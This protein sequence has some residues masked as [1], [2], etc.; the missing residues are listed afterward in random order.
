MEGV[1]V[2][3]VALMTFLATLV[4]VPGG[5]EG[6]VWSPGRLARRAGHRAARLMRRLG[7]SAMVS[8]LVGTD[9]G[10]RLALEASSSRAAIALGVGPEGSLAALLC[11]G[12]LVCALF[13]LLLASPLACPVAGLALVGMC[14]SRDAARGRRLRREV[15]GAMPGI[16]RTLAVAMGSG[17]TLAQAVEY[18]GAHERGPASAAFARMSLRLRCGM[19]T[20]EA[21]EALSGELDVP[22]A[23]LLATALVI[24]HRTGS[25]L[26]DLLVRSARLAERQG[27][28]ERLLS[29][30]TAQVRL[31]VR[32]VCLLPVIMV[33]VLTLLSPDFQR[34]LL[35]PAGIGCICAAMALDGLALAII[36]RMMRGVL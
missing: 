13:G 19:G 24:S 29:V 35:T 4:L 15:L 31:S 8:L 9:V 36:R 20:E 27:E 5:G 1:L 28:F 32:I 34:G 7:E 3:G 33:G 22:G 30:K 26:R 18:V 6:D 11:A 23:E 2:L 12:A 16:Y 17:Q 10:R 25:P 21:V 14:V